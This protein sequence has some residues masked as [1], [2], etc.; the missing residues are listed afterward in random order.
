MLEA[1]LQV[2]VYSV[3]SFRLVS[4]LIVDLQHKC[5]QQL[6]LLALHLEIEAYTTLLLYLLPEFLSSGDLRGERRTFQYIQ[7]ENKNI[8]TIPKTMPLCLPEV[9]LGPQVI[10]FI[11]HFF[12]T[13]IPIK[14]KLNQ[15]YLSN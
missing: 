11:H 2:S 7:Y 1:R 6:H 13:A 5:L 8:E 14:A 4:S 12:K 3:L 9:L 15:T 10:N